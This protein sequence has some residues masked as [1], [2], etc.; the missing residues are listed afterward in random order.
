MMTGRASMPRMR[1]A[2]TGLW[3]CTA[4]TAA[5][6]SC[7][8]LAAPRPGGAQ[9]LHAFTRLQL[10]DQ[11]WS[12]GANAGDLNNDGVADIIS[13]PWWWEG[14]DFRKRH[15]FYPATATFQLKLGPQT[16]LTVPGFE[17]TLGRDNK[18][19]DNFNCNG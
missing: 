12:E 11:F 1:C 6:F 8:L 17:G 15:E 18:Y 7:V 10:S 19:S 13:G 9:D 4:A 14:P 16:T 2:P 5:L 3:R